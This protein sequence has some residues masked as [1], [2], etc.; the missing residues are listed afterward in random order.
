[1]PEL[2]TTEDLLARMQDLPPGRHLIALAGAPASG[3]STLAEGL[4]EGLNAHRPGRAALLPMDGFHLDDR[5]LVARGHRARKGAP[6]TFDV[7]GLR[8]VLMRLRSRNEAEV[9]IPIFDR[10]IEIAR[11]GAA[12]IAQSVEVVVVEG[13]Y[14]LLREPPWDALQG[15]F[16]LTVALDVPEETLRARLVAR[17]EGYGLTPAQITAKL[18]D[19]DMPNGRLVRLASANADLILHGG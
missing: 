5:L 6:H 10:A 4:V 7:G 17:W 1:M 12:I 19:N 14:L 9:A 18:E 13:N 8:H 15:M 3:K 2:V 16:D 11:A